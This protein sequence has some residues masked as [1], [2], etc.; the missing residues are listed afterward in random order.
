MQIVR[1]LRTLREAALVLEASGRPQLC[2]QLVAIVEERV[3]YPARAI[4]SSGD[5]YED[6]AD[7][8][9][10]VASARPARSIKN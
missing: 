2:Q 9:A 4:A 5:T 10:R 6:K 1:D 8:R 3:T 7:A